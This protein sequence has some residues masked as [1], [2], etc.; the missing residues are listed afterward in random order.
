MPLKLIGA[1]L[2]RTGTK[3]TRQALNHLGFPCFHMV[4][5][6]ANLDRVGLLEDALAGRPD[7]ENES[8]YPV[9]Q[10]VVGSD[11]RNRDQQTDQGGDQGTGWGPVMRRCH[12]LALCCRG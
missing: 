7:F 3:S 5:M 8:L 4:D 2:G 12:A 6:F 10:D 9:S 11:R 1:S